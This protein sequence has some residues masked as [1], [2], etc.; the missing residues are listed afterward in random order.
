MKK[1]YTTPKLF[2]RDARCVHAVF[3]FSE[4]DRPT[5]AAQIAHVAGCLCEGLTETERAAIMTATEN[6]N[7]ST[8]LH[9]LDGVRRVVCHRNSE[10][11]A[12]PDGTA[13]AILLA[14]AL[15]NAEITFA[16]YGA[17]LDAVEPMPGLLFADICPRERVDE[18]VA[19]GAIVLDH[20]ASHEDMVRRFG[21]RGVFGSK[22]E[23]GASLAHEHVWLPRIGL[24][25]AS[26]AER[27]RAEQ[28][29]R[30]AAVRDTWQRD[31]EAW[32]AA[33]E[34]AAA[35]ALF[36]WDDW[37]PLHRPFS[38]GGGG[39]AFESMLTSGRPLYAARLR[40][41]QLAAQGATY[42]W[43]TVGTRLAIVNTLDTSDLAEIVDADVLV[44]FSIF[45]ESAALASGP[46][47]RIRYSFR[48]RGDYDVGSLAK[49]AS[50]GGG[51]R[52]AAGCAMPLEW[53][54]NAITQAFRFV[55]NY[56]GSRT[57]GGGA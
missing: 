48:A 43:T 8:L 20:H 18:H 44:G 9:A 41:A 56:E 38:D 55:E 42:F 24:D 12:C 5:P 27:A 19:A 47:S 2:K 3:V 34:Q 50:G 49:S 39:I 57:Q 52:G 30:L 29:A 33:S 1:P 11:T 51:H 32:V 22:T 31:H 21:E 4:S 37:Q 46:A 10:A 23:S 36:A 53:N 17:E 6:K 15:P 28:F 54:I 16:S 45:C 26:K 35:L 14:D 13:A 25:G 40:R 7:M